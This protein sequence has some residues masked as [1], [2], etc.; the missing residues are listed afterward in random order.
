MLHNR[1]PR[2]SRSITLIAR[3]PREL[4][5]PVDA[6]RGGIRQ[7]ARQVEYITYDVLWFRRGLANR[8]G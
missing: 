5:R 7:N 8:C 3:E 2:R 6:H 1:A 4:R